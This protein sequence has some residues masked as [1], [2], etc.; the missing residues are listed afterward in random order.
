VIL[1]ITSV[2]MLNGEQ[3]ASKLCGDGQLFTEPEDK[4]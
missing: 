4:I 2:G 3:Q 1:I